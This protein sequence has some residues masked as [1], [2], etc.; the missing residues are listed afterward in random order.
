[1]NDQRETIALTLAHPGSAHLR[2]AEAASAPT[3]RNIMVRQT[4]LCADRAV[5]R[6]EGHRANTLPRLCSRCACENRGPETILLHRLENG[7]ER[8][9]YWICEP[10]FANIVA[11]NERAQQRSIRAEMRALLHGAVWS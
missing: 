3:W 2:E 10:C 8:R 6:Y 7:K 5:Y 11:L 4:E 1:M 9:K